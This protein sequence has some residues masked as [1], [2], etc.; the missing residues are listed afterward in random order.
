MRRLIPTATVLLL[1]GT[2]VPNA[3]AFD[4]SAEILQP[5]RA[6]LGSGYC[7]GSAAPPCFDCSGFVTYLYRDHVPRLP[8]ISRDMALTGTPVNRDS[9]QPGD[10]VFFAT[11]ADRTTISHVAVYVGQNS[12]IHA[13]SD[14]PNRGVAMTELSSRYWRTRYAAARRVLAA[15]RAPDRDET[16]APMEFARGTY[17][18]D[19]KNGE[20][21]GRGTLELTNGDRYQGDFL[22]GQ[23]HGRGTYLWTSGATYEGS[24]ANGAFHG[25]GTY[26]ATNGST[27]RGTW[28]NGELTGTAA[29]EADYDAVRAETYFDVADSPWETFDGI[30]TG[31]FEAWFEAEQDAFEAW[32]ENN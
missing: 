19:L 21:H 16:D 9:L 15:S 17:R 2:G 25:S 23:F 10:L 8:R 1:V 30:V 18:G 6:L 7:R 28:S 24:F 22:D 3:G 5:A 12:I 26:T 20:P 31:D 14:G 4:L 13:I 32:K 27:T 11:G 29:T